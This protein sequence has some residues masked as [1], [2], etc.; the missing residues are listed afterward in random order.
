MTT[1]KRRAA[2]PR[3]PVQRTVAVKVDQSLKKAWAAS[4]S[5]LRRADRE[6]AFAFDRKYEAVGEILDHNPP[7]YLAGGVSTV[8]DFVRKYLPNETVRNVLRSARV[9]RYASPDEEKRYGA[10]KIDAV[11]DYLEAKHGKPASGRI[12]VDFGKLRIPRGAG[13]VP[14]ADATVAQLRDAT[15]KV[16]K[17]GATGAK[18]SPVVTEIVK[19]VPASAK[20]VT[21][22]YAGG[23][24]TIGRIPVRLFGDV[25]RSLAK[26]R[27]PVE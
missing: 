20:E 2:K 14:F 1:T 16:R 15:K 13:T 24:V 22:H 23:H 7:L 21:V 11:V 27:V 6:D 17:A 10:S 25:L 26:A 9:A 18:R 5:A 12:P 8:G 19:H 4:L 3:R